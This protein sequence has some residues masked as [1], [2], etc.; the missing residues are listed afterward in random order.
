MRFGNHRADCERVP[1][2]YFPF[3]CYANQPVV[4]PGKIALPVL[5]FLEGEGR[6]SLGII[7]GGLWGLGTHRLFNSFFH[8]TNILHPWVFSDKTA[9]FSDRGERINFALGSASRMCYFVVRKGKWGGGTLF[10]LVGCVGVFVCFEFCFSWEFCLLC[11]SS[12]WHE[13]LAYGRI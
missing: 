11:C 6:E 12:C 2:S 5:L 7:W 1:S 4:N 9:D 10:E 13:K 8:H 3:S